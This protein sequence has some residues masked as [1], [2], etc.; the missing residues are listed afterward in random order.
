[1]PPE[2][3]SNW[4]A[5]VHVKGPYVYL[6][7]EPLIAIDEQNSVKAAELTSSV[8]KLAEIV[9]DLGEP[10]TEAEELP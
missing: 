8:S 4:L 7:G 1:M 6:R 3:G 5:F 2:I 9:S 10:K